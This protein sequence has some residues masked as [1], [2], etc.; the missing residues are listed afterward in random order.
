VLTLRASL[1]FVQK[2]LPLPSA[3]RDGDMQRHPM[4][5]P[6]KRCPVDLELWCCPRCGGP[7]DDD[8][9]CGPCGVRP[10]QRGGVIDFLSDVPSAIPEPEV[11]AFYEARPF[12]GYAEQDDA[13]SSLQRSRNSPSLMGLDAAIPTDA[14][15]LDVGCGT[16]QVAALLAL[17]GRR[18]RVV[19]A[20][21]CLASLQEA[22]TFRERTSLESLSLV[23][24]DL[25]SLPLERDA[26]DVVHCRGVVHHN[27]DPSAATLR[28]AAHVKPG[29]ILVLGFYERIARLPHHARRQ[30][31]KLVRSPVTWLDPV[32]RR[33]D[34]D[35]EKRRTWIEDQ[36]RHPLEWSLSF[37]RV[38]SE[39]R[40]AGFSWLRSIPPAEDQGDFFASSPEPGRLPMFMRRVGWALSPES[41]DAGLVCYIAQRGER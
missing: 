10:L 27:S 22:A 30:L 29:G 31:A 3:D 14:T 24:G 11:N 39:L 41:E 15:V 12:P 40:E 6:E 17:K 37:P 4:R 16:A 26:F 19:G 25:F 23:R 38:V 32:L 34:L 5:R 36:Y 20:D 28:V 2:S 9:A 13:A 33:P 1:Y 18:R 8:Y 35:A 21:A 7:I